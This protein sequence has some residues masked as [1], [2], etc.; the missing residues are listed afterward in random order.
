[1]NLETRTACPLHERANIPAHNSNP[2]T[3]SSLKIA[4]MNCRGLRKSNDPSSSSQFIRYL[5][6][7]SLDI[8]ALQETHA[9]TPQL[10]DLFHK[11]FQ[12]SDSLWSPHCGLVCFSPVLSFSNT[13]F[14]VCGR[15]ITTTISHQSNIFDPVSV[16]VI[17]APASRNAR[18][19]FFSNVLQGDFSSL[20]SNPSRHILLG[21]FNYSYASHLS[22]R[23]RRPQAP[24]H[25]LSHIHSYYV[26]G[27]TPSDQ[28]ALPTFHRG[29]QQSCI[30]Y[31]FISRDLVSTQSLGRVHYI[32]PTWTDHFMVSLRIPL[33]TSAS[34]NDTSAIGKGLWRAHPRLAADPAFCKLLTTSISRTIATFD[35]TV[36]VELRWDALK[37]TVKQTAQS[38]SRKSAFTLAK[39]ETLLQKKRHGL[40]KKI[41]HDPECANVISPQLKIVEAQ[42]TDIQQY[43]VETLA[44]RAGIRWRELGE[45]SPG[46]LKRTVATRSARQLIPPLLH[47]THL[48]LSSTRDEMLD[49]ASTFYKNL[50]SPQPVEQ[51][52][53]DDLIGAIPEH[54]RLSEVDRSI[55]VSPITY[56][57]LLEGASRAPIRSSPGMDA[58]H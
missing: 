13:V 46:Y 24:D 12:A 6:T 31:I 52:A 20:P 34:N 48:T 9:D 7:H 58:L 41:E 17:Y 3:S 30:D 21:D 47:P 18:Y 25:W 15:I 39:A 57:D 33:L 45:L 40:L 5:R 38:F 23:S 27:V 22:P 42:L 50:Y 36:P 55:L 51:G 10:Q 44:L 16:S 29:T 2:I 43:H 37:S 35:D 19:V 14:S 8:L 1:M 28:A 4:T 26:D 54:L 53:I 56:H 11:Q 49:A 32:Q